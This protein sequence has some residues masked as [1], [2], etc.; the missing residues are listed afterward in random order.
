MEGQGVSKTG[1]PPEREPERVSYAPAV[2]WVDRGD[3]GAG[4]VDGE[5]GDARCQKDNQPRSACRTAAQEEDSGKEKGG[6]VAELVDDVCGNGCGHD[7]GRVPLWRPDKRTPVYAGKEGT[8]EE[9][10]V[11]RRA[12]REW[13]MAA[14]P[15]PGGR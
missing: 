9:S 11:A 15:S 5:P 6:P 14:E 3:P 4:D 1:E 8:D 10:T 12:I 2:Q 13:W 7:H